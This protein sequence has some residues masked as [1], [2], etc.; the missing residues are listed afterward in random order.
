MS[1]IL[2][3]NVNA[4]DIGCLKASNYMLLKFVLELNLQLFQKRK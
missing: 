1:E 4:K 2:L 3:I